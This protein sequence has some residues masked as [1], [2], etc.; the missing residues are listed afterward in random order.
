MMNEKILV[1]DDSPTVRVR[2]FM[3][4]KEADY[5]VKV[6][7]TPWCDSLISTWHPDLVLLDVNFGA[8]ESGL[9]AARRIESQTRIRDGL[10]VFLYS[11][12]SVDQLSRWVHAEPGIDGYIE[13][14]LTEPEFVARVRIAL[15]REPMN[16]AKW[17]TI[18]EELVT[19]MADGVDQGIGGK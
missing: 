8:T 4:L 17:D 5:R 6:S 7:E 15:F 3:T 18:V 11:S 14:G 10:L 16:A 1:V 12:C 9:L 13:K 2:T 19:A